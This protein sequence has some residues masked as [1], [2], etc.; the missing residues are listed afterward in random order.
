MNKPPRSHDLEA[1]ALAVCPLDS[2]DPECMELLR[3]VLEEL[4]PV[5][6][7]T[8]RKDLA[9]HVR[10]AFWAA[11]LMANRAL[12]QPEMTLQELYQSATRQPEAAFLSSMV[13]FPEPASDAAGTRSPGSDPCPSASH[14]RR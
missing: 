12:R 2:S 11:L 1:L 9:P 6:I 13:K 4:R 8:L 3:G 5:M 14:E 7:D 10:E